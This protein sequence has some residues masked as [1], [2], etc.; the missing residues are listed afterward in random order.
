MSSPPLDSKDM[1][2]RVFEA[3]DCMKDDIRIVYAKTTI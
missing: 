1:I 2:R 3:A